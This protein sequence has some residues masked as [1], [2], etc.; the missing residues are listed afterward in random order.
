MGDNRG[1]FG[2]KVR[3]L[4]ER[5]GLLLRQ[6]AAELD[7]DTAFLSKMERNEKKASR[8][9]VEKLAKILSVEANGLLTIWLSDRL[10]DTL[11]REPLAS[12]ALR[13]TERRLKNR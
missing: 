8:I 10:L 7:V 9:Q 6:L 11:A 12:K 1:S 13:L 3:L 4:R 5:R 2:D